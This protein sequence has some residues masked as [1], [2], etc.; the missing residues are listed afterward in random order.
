MYK[1]SRK[2]YLSFSSIMMIVDCMAFTKL[3]AM[4][5]SALNQMHAAGH[6]HTRESLSLPISVYA[7]ESEGN[8]DRKSETIVMSY[9]DMV[10]KKQ[11]EEVRTGDVNAE[12][13][14]SSNAS[15]NGFD[16]LCG[17]TP[18][19]GEVYALSNKEVNVQQQ[20]QSSQQ[21]KG[22]SL[23]WALERVKKLSRQQH[24][25]DFCANATATQGNDAFSTK[26]VQVKCAI[27]SSHSNLPENLDDELDKLSLGHSNSLVQSLDFKSFTEAKLM[28]I[29]QELSG[30]IAIMEKKQRF[31]LA[32]VELNGAIYAVGGFNGL[33]YLSSAERLDPREPSWKMLPMMNAGRGCHTLAELDEKIFSIG[34]YDTEAKEMVATVEMYE[35]RMPSWVM[36]EPMNYTR[37]Y[38]P[39]AVLGGS[40]YT[41]GGVKGEADTILDGVE[42]YKEGC[43]WVTTGL[44][45]VGRRCYCSAI[46][47]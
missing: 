20:Q 26:G 10:K 29:I 9:A 15:S 38:H 6:D 41:F 16:D 22:L 40:I 7:A 33:Q 46:V 13:A 5:S 45:S 27:L 31:A 34:A 39:S 24:N 2:D 23:K 37:G 19:E 43:G 1:T 28:D 25:S 21:D 17:D 30:R 35:P 44:K 4:A 47:L 11:I 36:V 12:H 42:R 8:N 18:P 14:R 3:Q 32:G